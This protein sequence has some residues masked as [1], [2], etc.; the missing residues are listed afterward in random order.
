MSETESSL[1]VVWIFD[2]NRRVYHKDEKGYGVGAP[3]WREHWCKHEIVGE[4]KRSWILKYGK[5]IP[6][7]G[8]RDIAFTEEEINRAAF[9]QDNRHKIADA[10]RCITDYDTLKKVAEVAGWSLT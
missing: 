4:T 5:K 10:V 7:S 6:K 8:G 9:I 3:I 1:G 2:I